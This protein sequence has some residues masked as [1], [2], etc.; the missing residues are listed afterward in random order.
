VTAV[1]A[2]RGGGEVFP[3]QTYEAYELAATS[4]VQYVEFDVRRLADGTLVCFHDADINGARLTT[5]RYPDLCARAGY[6]VVVLSRLMEVI[7]GRT[8]GHID[9]KE[10]DYEAQVVAQAREVLGPES[11]L[12]TSMIEGSLRRIADTFPGTQTGLSLGRGIGDVPA[13]QLPSAIAG[14]LFPVGRLRACAATW[15]AISKDLAP[16]V[17]GRC[18]RHGIRTMV[19]TVDRHDQID[20]LLRDPRVDVVVTNRPLLALERLARLRSAP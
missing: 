9:L 17:L 18:R 14:D 12:V 1:S 11:F 5:L 3:L 19:W 4:G 6:D 7:A 20:R 15:A 2:H 10:T 13:H 16:W 8:Y